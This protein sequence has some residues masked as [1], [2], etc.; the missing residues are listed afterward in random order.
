MVADPEKQARRLLA[1]VGLD[2]DPACLEFHENK[3]VVRTAS[4]NQVRKP[5][6]SSSVARW[7]HFEKHLAPLAEIVNGAD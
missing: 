3:R 7:K 5:V 2:W 6:Y 1:H 4:L